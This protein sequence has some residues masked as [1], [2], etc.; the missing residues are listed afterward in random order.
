[1][2]CRFLGRY[3]RFVSPLFLSYHK[4]Q[5]RNKERLSVTQIHTTS[6]LPLNSITA[7]TA[8]MALLGLIN[9]G[10]TTAF[11]AIVSLSV[12]SLYISYL[13]PIILH[14]VRRITGP[15]LHYGPFKLGRILGPVLNIVG[16]VYST[17]IVVF[18]FFP[19]YQP[20][21]PQNMNY[22]CVVFGAVLGCSAVVWV[23]RGRRVYEGVKG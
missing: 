14:L 17:I 22:A 19:P 20:V 23:V 18:L 16:V 10:S 11:N 2:G 6:T 8:F 12:V 13:I 1:M 5:L 4:S 9:I 3:P 7:S 15:E 21:T